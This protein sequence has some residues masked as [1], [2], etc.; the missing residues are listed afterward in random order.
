MQK[1]NELQ[2]IV[3]ELCSPAKLYLGVS[4]VLMILSI[5]S[6]LTTIFPDRKNIP[7]GVSV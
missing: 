6:I 1:I 3:E 2:T 4:T 5:V 7:T